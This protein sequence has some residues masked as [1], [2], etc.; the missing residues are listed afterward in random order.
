MDNHISGIYC[1]KSLDLK[2]YEDNCIILT[3]LIKWPSKILYFFTILP[4]IL[5]ADL[6]MSKLVGFLLSDLWLSEM[7]LLELVWSVSM[8]PCVNVYVGAH[9]CM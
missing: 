8:C 3:N 1:Q 4:E 7:Y 5:R 6:K 2:K 9:M